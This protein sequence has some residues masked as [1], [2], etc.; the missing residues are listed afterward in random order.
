MRD[1]LKRGLAVDAFVI[2]TNR[3]TWGGDKHP[4]RALERYRSS[5]G[6]AAKLVVIAMSANG[7]SIADPDDPLQMDVAGFDASVPDVI[8]AFIKGRPSA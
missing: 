6:I 7:Y 4:V 3:E 1:A 2:V 8:A 5:S